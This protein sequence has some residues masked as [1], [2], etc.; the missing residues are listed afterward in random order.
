MRKIII[1]VLVTLAAVA[2]LGGVAVAGRVTAPAQI[3]GRPAAAV[4]HKS[5]S[6]KP[7]PA[8]HRH[9]H[10]HHA[11]PAP[12]AAAPA[13]AA[14]APVAPANPQLTNASAVVM[15]F[16][17]DLTNHDYADAWALGGDNIGGSDYNSW[18][19]GYATTASI[20]VDSYGTWDDGTVWADISALQTDGATRTYSGTYTVARGVIV[21]AD[22]TQ[23]S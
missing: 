9:R 16:Y 3:A 11:Q 15:Q 13:P 22:I 18:I 12:V 17:Q 7:S 19:T 6:P 23:T 8:R 10:H 4:Q 14:P 1:T 21:S 2:V 5:P 20:T